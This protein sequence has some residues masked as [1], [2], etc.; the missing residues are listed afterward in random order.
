M[1]VLMEDTLPFCRVG[2]T[3]VT[4]KKGDI[5]REVEASLHAMDVLGGRVR[6]TRAVNLTGLQDARA[7]VVV[8]KVKVTP[9]KFPRRPG[10]SAKRPL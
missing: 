8:E 1:R 6:E 9:A 7:L 10:L 2:G 3:V 4:L 5:S